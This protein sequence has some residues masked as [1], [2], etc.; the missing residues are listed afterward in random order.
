ML[1]CVI[2]FIIQNNLVH[3]HYTRSEIIFKCL[4]LAIQFTIDYTFGTQSSW[5]L[6]AQIFLTISFDRNYS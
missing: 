2:S 3:S 4:T 5:R 1:M 6:N